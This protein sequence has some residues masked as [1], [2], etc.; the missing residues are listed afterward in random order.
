[1]RVCI[2]YI[3]T[4]LDRTIPVQALPILILTRRVASKGDILKYGAIEYLDKSV[5][6]K[7]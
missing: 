6:V 2:L 4:S 7:Y 3:L 1:M 5:R